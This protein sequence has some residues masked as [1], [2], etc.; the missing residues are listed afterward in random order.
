[1][2]EDIPLAKKVRSMFKKLEEI[3]KPYEADWEKIAQYVYYRR[4]FFDLKEKQGQSIARDK[5]DGTAS[6][7]ATNLVHGF[8]GYMVSQSIK[9]LDLDFEDKELEEYSEAMQWLEDL[10][11]YLYEV[12]KKT[13]FYS[14]INENLMD[15]VCFESCLYSENDEK[16]G[17]IV[18]SERHPIEI[19]TAV[20]RYG[21]ADTIFRRYKM[22]AREIVKQ[23]PKENISKNII[24]NADKSSS[25]YNEHIIIHGVFPNEDKVD[26]SKQSKD[27][28]FRS[29]YFEEEAE[30]EDAILSDSG[31]DSNPY[32]KWWWDRNSTE[33]Y[34][35]TP[36]HN[37]LPET[38]ALNQVEKNVLE[39]VEKVVNP[40]IYA[41]GKNRGSIRT[42]PGA[43]NYY[44]NYEAER[45]EA[46]LQGIQLPITFEE[47][48]DMR[49]KIR[50]YYFN[51]FFLIL[52]QMLQ[53]Q[54]TATEVMEVQG[55]KAVIIAP[56]IG[57]YETHFLD[58]LIERT[59][60]LEYEAGRIPEIPPVLEDYAGER[61]EEGRSSRINI[62]YIGPLATLQ[63][64]LY[65]TKGVTHTLSS[66]APM[67]ELQM[68]DAPILDKFDFD[69][70]AEEI[71]RTQ[72][73]PAKAIRSDRD[74]KEMRKARAQAQQ[75]AQQAEMAEKAAKAIPG[76][77]KKV[78][79]G[80][81]IDE[82]RRGA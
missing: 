66:I 60:K 44:Q 37:A 68:A 42:Y 35:R 9:W 36:S 11:H 30:K 22:S 43:V 67:A 73:M 59:Y 55:E 70:M 6:Q 61:K 72:G 64:R 28:A 15:S 56:I 33:W 58:P 10:I 46:I 13:N 77:S 79:E 34:S 32:I 39:A 26:G 38:L 52:S 18:Y 31:Y 48:E 12:F 25:M 49:N 74:V 2:P 23:F 41:P 16:M 78:E 17:K 51:D 75:A 20:N 14:S 76:M 21:I 47:R 8:Q 53:K 54:K 1:M 27:K 29:I 50:R 63:E 45:T 62:K 57:R 24:E 69:V 65:K 81:I 19:Y 40:P 4:E 82:V 71:A 7:A 80:S 5:Y 3:R